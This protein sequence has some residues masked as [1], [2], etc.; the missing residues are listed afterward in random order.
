M[1]KCVG[2]LDAWRSPM[3]DTIMNKAED[4][5]Q[6]SA[7]KRPYR[8]PKLQTFGKVLDLTQGKGKGSNDHHHHHHK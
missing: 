4:C 5:P 6:G 3:S 8:Q 2:F 1:A 7:V